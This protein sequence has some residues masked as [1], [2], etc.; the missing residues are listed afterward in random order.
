MVALG[1]A[2]LKAF[3]TAAGSLAAASTGSAR[4]ARMVN[5]ARIRVEVLRVGV[6]DYLQW[7]RARKDATKSYIM[8]RLPRALLLGGPRGRAPR[9]TPRRDRPHGPVPW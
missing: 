2:A 4:A 5:E 1:Y 9:N 7:E 6:K 3:M 8:R